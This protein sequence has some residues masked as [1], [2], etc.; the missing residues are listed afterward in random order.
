[1]L[2]ARPLLSINP[3]LHSIPLNSCSKQLSQNTEG[4]GT[5]GRRV[6]NWGLGVMAFP[7]TKEGHEL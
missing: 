1:M 4:E 2:I 5:G 3:H 6:E 7:W